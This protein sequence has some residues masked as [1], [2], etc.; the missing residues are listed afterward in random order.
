M[1]NSALQSVQTM[2]TSILEEI[3]DIRKR[4]EMDRALRQMDTLQT[5][6]TPIQAGGVHPPMVQPVD[7][8]PTLTADLTSDIPQMNVQQPL[9]FTPAENYQEVPMMTNNVSEVNG[10]MVPLAEN[11]KE[12]SMSTN[13]DTA[14]INSGVIPPVNNYM[15]EEQSKNALQKL[16]AILNKQSTTTSP[17]YTPNTFNEKSRFSIDSLIDTNNPLSYANVAAMSNLPR[18]KPDGTFD[19]RE[20]INE[21]VTDKTVTLKDTATG[22]MNDFMTMDVSKMSREEVSQHLSQASIG[23]QEL[24]AEAT[25]GVVG[26]GTTA[27][28]LMMPLGL[29]AA[30]GITGG[31]A[32]DALVTGAKEANVYQEI[33][34][35]DGYKAFNALESTGDFGSIGI[36]IEDRQDL[37]KEIRHIANANFLEDEE[38]SQILQGALDHKLLKSTQDVETFAKKF[39]Q[40]VETAKKVTTT[41][42]GTIE[43]SMAF[44]GEMESRGVAINDM[45]AVASFSKVGSSFSGEDSLA[46]SERM[47]QVADGVT[48]GTSI[49]TANITQGVGFASYAVEAIDQMSKEGDGRLAQLIKNSGGAGEVAA[50]MEVKATSFLQ[51]EGVDQLL[52]LYGAAFEQDESGNWT[53][54]N[55]RLNEMQDM[56]YQELLNT[57]AEHLRNFDAGQLDELQKQAG[58]I[59]VRDTDYAQRYGII[60]G[61]VDQ[62]TSLDPRMTREN[63]L[64]NLGIVDPTDIEGAELMSEMLTVATDQNS[65][66]QYD[67]LAVHEQIVAASHIGSPGIVDRLTF[68]YKGLIGEPI[69]DLGQSISDKVGDISH[70]VNER[71]VGMSEQEKN[72]LAAGTSILEEDLLDR[73]SERG[74]RYEALEELGVEGLEYQETADDMVYNGDTGNMSPSERRRYLERARAG[75]LS[76][77]D[78]DNLQ[79]ELEDPNTSF[80]RRQQISHILN[81]AENEPAG[82][83]GTITDKVGDVGMWGLS[84]A[85]NIGDKVAGIFVDETLTG[86]RSGILSGTSSKE[87]IEEVQE[88]LKKELPQAEKDFAKAV[89]NSNLTTDEKA[90]LDMALAEDNQELVKQIA[91]MDRTVLMEV[92]KLQSLKDE[93][94]KVREIEFDYMSD[95]QSVDSLISST[96]D[97]YGILHASGAYSEE[98]YQAYYKDDEKTLRTTATEDKNKLDGLTDVELED[99]ARSYVAKGKEIFS[100]MSTQELSKISEYLV[101]NVGGLTSEDLMDEQGKV[102]KDK[103]YEVVMQINQGATTRDSAAKN[104]LL[105]KNDDDTI[106][107]DEKNTK[108]LKN[109]VSDHEDAIVTMAETLTKEITVM[110]E[111][112]TELQKSQNQRITSRS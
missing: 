72:E 34:L 8:S 68:G 48:A 70:G 108:E 112:I 39:S 69:G 97:L 42:G 60:D 83:L 41:L 1:E 54:N 18:M 20:S 32:A 13:N 92:E 38:M 3:R 106:A 73:F 17:N 6:M 7:P 4:D 47:L 95:V 110:N 86:D 40:I 33:L 9:I 79:Q 109:A 93:A 21:L 80:V 64:T 76:F 46:Y 43:E 58:M 29:G 25:A 2:Q 82:V 53:I 56:S 107:Y 81:E 99:T 71:I 87:A 67:A 75:S 52:G 103:M 61:I 59:A 45:A 44:L 19:A 65:T 26:I 105:G 85:A 36:G 15:A 27:A 49:G 23:T 57:S 74:E 11:H 66:R 78:M 12:L 37:S 24:A 90:E 22:V 77:E 94:N 55:N 98:M 111:M 51:N 10:G 102:D 30:V 16:E 96:E 35:K 88:R 104:A 28:A 31:I 91:S 50:Q 5:N 63:A 89:N 62:M 101:S 100:N 84:A 14:E